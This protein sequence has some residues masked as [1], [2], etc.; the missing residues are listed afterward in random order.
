M[1]LN[2]IIRKEIADKLIERRFKKQEQDLDAEFAKFAD[3]LYRSFFTTEEHELIEKCP[4]EWFHCSSSVDFRYQGRYQVVKMSC[5]R[6]IP[7][8][9]KRSCKDNIGSAMAKRYGALLARREALQKVTFEAHCQAMG[10][11]KSVN[12][13]KRLLETWPEVAAFIPKEA[14]AK[15]PTA[16]LAIPMK[17]LN[18]TLGLP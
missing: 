13:T 7:A 17:E 6:K 3:D 16:T 18:A 12:T 9:E 15:A 10:V 5:T 8:S 14:P 2:R 1:I 4:S 11:L